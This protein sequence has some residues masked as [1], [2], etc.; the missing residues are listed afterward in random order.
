MQCDSTTLIG[1]VV[2]FLR[3]LILV[4]VLLLNATLAFAQ[5]F[6][7]KNWIWAAPSCDKPEMAKTWWDN[8]NGKLGVFLLTTNGK[9]FSEIEKLETKT[10]YGVGSY[11]FYYGGSSSEVYTFYS[12]NTA[13]LTERITD[14]KVEVANGFSLPDKMPTGSID[15]CDPKSSAAVKTVNVIQ[16]HFAALAEIAN[17]NKTVSNGDYIPQACQKDLD[18]ANQFINYPSMLCTALIPL[19]MC[20]KE[21][22]GRSNDVAKAMASCEQTQQQEA[23]SKCTRYAQAIQTCAP[24]SNFPSCM[25][26][27]GFYKNEARHECASG[28]SASGW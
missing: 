2:M 1:A 27:L 18:L 17:Q 13:K 11:R 19:S 25:N 8:G 23:S 24:A 22:G 4:T 14:G 7:Y 9:G 3:S 15:A 28:M 21:N 10:Q 20:L 12:N 16:K 5:N 6:P 26:K